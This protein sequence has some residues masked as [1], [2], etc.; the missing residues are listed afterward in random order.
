MSSSPLLYPAGPEAHP[1]PD[2][3]MAQARRQLYRFFKS[4]TFHYS[5]LL[6]VSLDVACLFAGVAFL[7]ETDNFV[8]TGYG[9]QT[10]SSIC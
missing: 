2:R 1:V 10:S 7:L 4:K 6:L 8:L 3:R 9:A 5:I